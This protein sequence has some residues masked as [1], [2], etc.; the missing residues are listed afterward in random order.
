MARKKQP[1]GKKAGERQLAKA[2]VRP[3]ALGDS[4]PNDWFEAVILF[5]AGVG[6]FGGV[7]ALWYL[8]ENMP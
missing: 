8:I 4:F 3:D 5:V 6:I 7:L 2:I 1:K